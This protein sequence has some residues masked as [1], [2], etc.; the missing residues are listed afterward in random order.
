VQAG[1]A[2]LGLAVRLALAFKT[3]GHRADLTTIRVAGALAALAGR[4]AV[5]LA[6]VKRGA[7]LALRHRL[8]NPLDDEELDTA[9]LTEQVEAVAQADP[10]TPPVVAAP[11]KKSP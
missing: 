7:V 1:E 5:S 2:E 6:D 9:Q 11:E 4:E 8:A 3:E 10:N